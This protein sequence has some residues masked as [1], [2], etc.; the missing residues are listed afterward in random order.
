[1]RPFSPLGEKQLRGALVLLLA[2][3]TVLTVKIATRSMPPLLFSVPPAFS[4]QA[5]RSTPIQ[6]EMDG[7]GEGIYF[8]EGSV[9]V[10]DVLQAAAPAQARLFESDVTGEDVSRGD[11]LIV[12]FKPPSIRLERMEPRVILAL[13]MP[14]DV[15]SAGTEDLV[16]IPG[17]GPVTAAAIVSHRDERGGFRS[18]GE[19]TAVRG[20]GE[21]RLQ[22]L[23]RHLTL[24]TGQGR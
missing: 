16:M 15:N 7:P 6:V 24:D 18:M 8:F 13:G 11:R 1:M 19:L 10:R 22:E 4:G 21:K 5:A 23:K 2:A 20:I 12:L 14:L 3:V 17:I 9:T